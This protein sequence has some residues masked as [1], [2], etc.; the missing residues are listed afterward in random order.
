MIKLRQNFT[1]RLYFRVR[2]KV[3]NLLTTTNC[4]TFTKILVYFKERNAVYKTQANLN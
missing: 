3:F 2:E 1:A 4:T